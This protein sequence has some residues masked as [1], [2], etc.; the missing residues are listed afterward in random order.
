MAW[1][2]AL[3]GERDYEDLSGVR[4]ADFCLEADVRIKIY[5]L[6]DDQTAGLP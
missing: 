1:G 4:R 6:M 5:A 3:S 2:I